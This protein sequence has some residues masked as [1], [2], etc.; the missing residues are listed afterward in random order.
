MT[1]TPG[2]A[3]ARDL[4]SL[5]HPVTN[6]ALHQ[7]RGPLVIERGKGVYVWDNQGRQYIEGMAGLWCT[8]LGYGVEE[9][10]DTAAEQMRELAYAHMF[11]GKSHEPGIALAEKLIDMVPLDVSRVFY[12]NSGSEANDSQIKL[13][14]YYNN[15]VGR[16]NKKKIISRRRAYH[17]VTIASGSLTGLPVNHNDFDLPIAGILH[18]DCP[19]HYRN[20]EPGETEESFATRLAQNLETLILTEGPDTVAAFIAEPVMGAGGVVVPPPSYFEK[21]QAV[22]KKYDVLFIDDEVICGFGRTGNPFGCETFEMEADTMSIAKALSSAYL[23][24]SAVMLPEYLYEPMI[25]SSRR[26]GA[27]GHGFTYSGHPVCAAVALRNIEL[28]EERRA[29]EHAEAMAPYF[30]RRL[31]AF[32]DHPLVGEA[33]GIGLIGGCELVRDKSSGE[34]FDPN[35]KVGLHCMDRCQDHGL[36]VRAIGDTVAF[37]PPLIISETQIDEIFDRF[38]KALEDT[39]Q[40]V[41]KEAKKG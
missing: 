27:F 22:L 19:H 13:I 1:I 20:A 6:L 31:R 24:I 30:Q 9:L 18:T 37:C 33:R 10:A 14:W 7:E 36:L 17:G 16:P 11:G 3:E 5:L 25:E 8:A 12:G 28:L 41:E 23:P 2:S 34:A 40:W 39:L 32:G 15:A 4:E 35:Q 26:H 21:V 29:M 38:E